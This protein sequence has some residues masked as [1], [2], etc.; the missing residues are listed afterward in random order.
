MERILEKLENF[1]LGYLAFQREKSFRK[2]DYLDI[3]EA[4]KMVDNKES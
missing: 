1:A 3:E 4:E 2:S